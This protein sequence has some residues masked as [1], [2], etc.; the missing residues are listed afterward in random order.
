MAPSSISCTFPNIVPGSSIVTVKVTIKT[1]LKSMRKII[2]KCLIG[3][4]GAVF[5]SPA[6]QRLPIQYIASNI[7]YNTIHRFAINKAGDH[8]IQGRV[9]I[10]LLFILLEFSSVAIF[11][12]SFDPLATYKQ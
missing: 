6:Q 10:A 3:K 5:G 4:Y 2:I 7:Q 1:T 11:D 8:T 12:L 9:R